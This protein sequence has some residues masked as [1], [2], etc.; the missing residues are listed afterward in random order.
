MNLAKSD[1]NSF[2][3]NISMEDNRVVKWSVYA[4]TAFPLVDYALRQFVHPVG[5]IWDKLVFL[6]LLTVMAFRYTYGFRPARFVWQKFA[7]YFF[8]FGFALMLAN[9][10]QPM[11]AIEGYRID[12]YYIFFTF[13][14]PFVVGPKDVE[15]VLY[16]GAAFAVL[17][18]IHGVYQYITKAPIPASWV[19]VGENVRTR[20]YSVLISP[21]ELGSY[22]ALMIPIIVGLAVYETDR[23][24]KWVYR[25]GLI[26]C[27]MTLLFTFSRA[28]WLS[29]GLSVVIMAIVFERRLLIVLAIA[30]V[31]AFFVP[32]I[33]HRITDLFS[34]VYW[35]KSAQ[36]GRIAKWQQAFDVMTSNPLFGAGLGH[37]GGAVAS[38]YHY[39]LYSDNYY[40]KTL[41]ETG[42]VGLTLFIAMHLALMRDLFRRIR[43]VSGRRKFVLIGGM[44]GLLAVLIHNSM[45][46]VFE[47]AP[48]A[49]SY[50]LYASVF[51]I[52]SQKESSNESFEAS[53]SIEKVHMN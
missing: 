11:V 34:P 5:V 22:M 20:V 18:A 30:I 25:L 50:F 15:K 26:P 4:L 19:D 52:W 37:Y 28:A 33:H 41:G 53:I 3:S 23:W 9:L 47:Y 36:A 2:I 35:I 1:I 32:A 49:L 21:N 45:E 8:V 12:V 42:I 43:R 44:T 13:L 17:V 46:N 10:S 27:A 51:L 14:M 29:L 39:S 31:V 16:A 40:A 24:R 7:V 48:M 6:I 38:V